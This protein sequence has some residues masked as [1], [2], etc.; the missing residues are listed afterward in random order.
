[1]KAEE[2][3]TTDEKDRIERHWRWELGFWSDEQRAK[4]LFLKS[5]DWSKVGLKAWDVFDVFRSVSFTRASNNARRARKILEYL[6]GYWDG[7]KWDM[8][9]PL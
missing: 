1:M 9:S 6:N 8:K 2:T 4:V 7:R 5:F 3:G